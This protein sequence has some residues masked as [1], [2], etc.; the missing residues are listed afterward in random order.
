ML[1]WLIAGGVLL[2][3]ILVFGFLYVLGAI[4]TLFLYGAINFFFPEFGVGDG[5]K[6]PMLIF[7]FWPAYAVYALFY[8]PPKFI[9]R[10]IVY[11]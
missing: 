6:N 1:F 11:G 9:L 4:A 5:I 2:A 7:I 8:L 3:L 10:R